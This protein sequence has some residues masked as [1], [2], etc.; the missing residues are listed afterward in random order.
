[1]LHAPAHARAHARASELAPFAQRT[2]VLLGEFTAEL[3]AVRAR[4][5]FGAVAC[6][7]ERVAQRGAR[8]TM[9]VRKLALSG[10]TQAALVETADGHPLGRRLVRE[11]AGCGRFAAAV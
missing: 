2:R 10:H 7:A 8:A 11:R 9:N 6:A 4:V 5:A 1:M 3:M